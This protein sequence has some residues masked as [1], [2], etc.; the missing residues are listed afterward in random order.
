MPMMDRG[1]PSGIPGSSTTTGHTLD[2]NMSFHAIQS[3]NPI[4][5]NRGSYPGSYPRCNKTSIKNIK[6]FNNVQH[7]STNRS[8]TLGG[9]VAIVGQKGPDQWPVCSVVDSQEGAHISWYGS[10]TGGSGL[11][12]I[13]C[14]LSQQH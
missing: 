4:R 7:Q 1:S 5:G 9:S 8:A 12:P 6:C 14:R 11:S 3:S 2:K 13:S 10:E